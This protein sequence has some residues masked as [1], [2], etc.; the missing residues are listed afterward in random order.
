MS[1]ADFNT[2]WSM[3]GIGGALGEGETAANRRMAVSTRYYY[4]AMHDVPLRQES[5]FPLNSPN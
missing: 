5:V 4:K 1:A 3:R 2:S